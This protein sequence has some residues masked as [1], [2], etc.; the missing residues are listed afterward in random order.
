[1]VKNIDLKNLSK[2]ISLLILLAIVY[3]DASHNDYEA[4]IVVYLVVGLIAGADV[5]DIVKQYLEPENKKGK[6]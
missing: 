1:M 4:N 3:I 5:R 6:G 2:I